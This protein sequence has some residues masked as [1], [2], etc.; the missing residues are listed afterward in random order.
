MIHLDNNYPSFNDGSISASPKYE[1]LCNYIKKL[2]LTKKK[3]N[4]EPIIKNIY[5]KDSGFI[6]AINQKYK[7]IYN[8]GSPSPSY[9]PGHSSL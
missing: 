2:G 3:V 4:K 5:F 9:Q 6:S 1:S 7:L 8:V